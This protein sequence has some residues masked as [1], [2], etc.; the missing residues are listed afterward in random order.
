MPTG[1]SAERDTPAVGRTARLRI[2]GGGRR[3]STARSAAR[4][5]EGHGVRTRPARVGRAAR[6][7]RRRGRPV[8][9]ISRRAVR[10]DLVIIGWRR[11]DREPSERPN[12]L[13]AGVHS[14]TTA[15]HRHRRAARPAASLCPNAWSG[16]T[17]GRLRLIDA[18]LSGPRSAVLRGELTISVGAPPSG[19]AGSDQCWPCWA[20]SRVG[21][22]GAAQVAHACRQLVWAATVI[23]VSEATMIAERAGLDMR[24]AEQLAGAGGRAGSDAA[25]AQLPPDPGRLRRGCWP[26][27]WP[28]RPMRPTAAG[29]A[30]AWWPSHFGDWRISGSRRLGLADQDLSTAY[31]ILAATQVVSGELQNH[32]HQNDDHQNADDRANQSAV[33]GPSSPDGSLQAT[34]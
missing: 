21:G 19:Y 33:H 16:Q 10:C 13:Q 18:P 30:R 28:S 32:N 12:G 20:R 27:L 22:M 23:G 6:A 7:R 25:R 14:P 15:D 1:D 34:T 11:G 31:R 4:R 5:H 17:A 29:F 2:P 8:R 9:P 26:R 24:S 3:R